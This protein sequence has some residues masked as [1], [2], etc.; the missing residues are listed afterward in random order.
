MARVVRRSFAL[1]D[2]AWRARRRP[3]C[4]V[5]RCPPGIPN[6]TA[7]H[8]TYLCREQAPTNRPQRC[9]GAY[10]V[11][12]AGGG[13]SPTRIPTRRLPS[14]KLC[15]AV[16]CTIFVDRTTSWGEMTCWNGEIAIY[17]YHP[18]QLAPPLPAGSIHLWREAAKRTRTQCRKRKEKP[19]LSS[20]EA[21]RRCVGSQQEGG[22]HWFRERTWCTWSTWSA[23]GDRPSP[24][25]CSDSAHGS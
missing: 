19:V 21:D 18:P 4:S 10:W 20:R 16:R 1:H 24:F 25:C 8:P 3:P 13:P 12:E 23:I 9:R 5:S 11:V 15:L 2:S 7:S 22:F 14:R 17:F 6:A